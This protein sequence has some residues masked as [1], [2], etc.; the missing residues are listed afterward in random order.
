[1]KE[2]ENLF[3]KHDTQDTRAIL[4]AIIASRNKSKPPTPQ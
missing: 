4:N 2:K 1:M 3:R